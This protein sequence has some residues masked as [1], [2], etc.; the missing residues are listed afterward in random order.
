MK[1]ILIIKDSF[2]LPVY[3]F[4]SLGIKEVRAIDMRL[5]DENVVEYA[6]AY[7]PDLVI[8]MYNADSF[9]PPMFDFHLSE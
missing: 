2:S 5:F 8:L 1:K 4:L 7:N 9:A 6:A 3:S